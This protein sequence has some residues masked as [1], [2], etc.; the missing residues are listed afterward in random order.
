MERILNE[1]TEVKELFQQDI[2]SI[3][4]MLD[5]YQ[6]SERI[7]GLKEK[8]QRICSY[9]LEIDDLLEEYE[10]LDEIS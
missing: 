3:R 8:E 2:L 7:A 1:L 9:C 10:A 6:D 5:V 4:R